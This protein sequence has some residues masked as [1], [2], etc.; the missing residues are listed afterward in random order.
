MQL[1]RIVEAREEII[2]NIEAEH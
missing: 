1:V 2:N